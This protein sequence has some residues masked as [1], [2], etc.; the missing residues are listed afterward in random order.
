MK[1]FLSLE[2]MEYERPRVLGIFSTN[3]RARAACVIGQKKA[4]IPGCDYSVEEYELNIY[5]DE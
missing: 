2:E 1:V 4:I 5:Q 3:E